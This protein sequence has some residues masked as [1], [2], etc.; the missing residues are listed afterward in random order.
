MLFHPRVEGPARQAQEPGSLGLVATRLL[1]GLQNQV[2]ESVNGTS[3][4][5]LEMRNTILAASGDPY[6]VFQ[7]T[8]GTISVLDRGEAE[9]AN[10]S[11][12]QNY[13]ISSS[14]SFQN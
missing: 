12:L 4:R 14:S 8:G 10:G 11:I 1:Q 9:E 2:V 13:G 6:M 7:F 5:N 3:I